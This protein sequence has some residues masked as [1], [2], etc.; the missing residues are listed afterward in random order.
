MPQKNL[1]KIARFGS[2]YELSRFSKPYLAPRFKHTYFRRKK[3]KSNLGSIIKLS[4]NIWRSKRAI[5]RYVSVLTYNTSE[6][7]FA[8]FTYAQPQH[9]MQKAIEDWRSFTRRM[10]KSFPTVA[11]IRV[12]ERHKSGAVHFHAVMFNLPENLACHMKKNGRYWIHACRSDAPCERRLRQVAGVWGLGFVD[13][14]KVRSVRAI[15]SYVAK[16]LTK[17]DP[18]WTLFGNHIVSCNSVMYD[19]LNAAKAEGTYWELS[20]SKDSEGVYFA[21]TD[22]LSREY[23]MEARTFPTKW[24]GDCRFETYRVYGHEP[25]TP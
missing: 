22:L 11:F 20:S 1:T 7:V 2:T 5:R 13:L 18:D 23:S 17:G 25:D 14:Q 4:Q 15:G 24:L 19:R 21:M 6:P 10:K 8:T 3:S 9:D 12:P 16:Y